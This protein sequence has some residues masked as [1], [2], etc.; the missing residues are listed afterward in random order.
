MSEETEIHVTSPSSPTFINLAETFV[1]TDNR[2]WIII[3]FSQQH[4]EKQNDSINS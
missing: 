1:R 2:R 4:P 3:Q